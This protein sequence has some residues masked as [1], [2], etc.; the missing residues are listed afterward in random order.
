M[1]E[2]FN[3]NAKV[4]KLTKKVG[5]GV[6]LIVIGP[7][8]QLWFKWDTRVIL[9]GVPECL[10]DLNSKIQSSL[11]SL[12]FKYRDILINNAALYTHITRDL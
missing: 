6:R 12:Y 1:N 7:L 8:H 5:R 3:K 11:F 10:I 2:K 4:E 9:H